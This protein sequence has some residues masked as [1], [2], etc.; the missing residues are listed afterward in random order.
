MRIVYPLL[1]LAVF[2]LVGCEKET[3]LDIREGMTFDPD[4]LIIESQMKG[5]ELYTWQSGDVWRF[6]LMTA[7]NRVKTSHEITTNPYI[8]NGREQVKLILRQLPSGE[9]ITWYG[10]EWVTA[11]VTGVT[12]FYKIPPLLTQYDVFSFARKNAV[13]ITVIP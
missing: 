4:T 5:W 13:V 11:N 2:I 3:V 12:A 1:V 7:T 10:P 8:V 6:S 9:E